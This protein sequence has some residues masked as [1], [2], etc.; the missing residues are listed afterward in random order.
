[1]SDT[2]D[3][4]EVVENK[5][6]SSDFDVVAEQIKQIYLG[7]ITQSHQILLDGYHQIGQ[8][9]LALPSKYEAVN[10]LAR[11]TGISTRNLYNAAKFAEKFPNQTELPEGENL[12][13]NK[14]V[15]KYLPD[16]HIECEH[17]PETII[18]CRKCHKRLETNKEYK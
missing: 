11:V 6:I 7:A 9:I 15:T 2:A 17:E 13:W 12:T 10:D 5:E 14:V 8:L 3:L 16:D 18:I 4:P 1:M